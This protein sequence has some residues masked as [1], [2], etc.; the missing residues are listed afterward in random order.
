MKSSIKNVLLAKICY[1]T[2]TIEINYQFQ[3]NRFKIHIP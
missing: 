3:F 2:N 1:K